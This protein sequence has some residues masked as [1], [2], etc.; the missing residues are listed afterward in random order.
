MNDKELKVKRILFD[1]KRYIQFKF[2]K[3]GLRAMKNNDLYTVENIAI[4]N[5]KDKNSEKI[6]KLVHNEM[7][8]RRLNHLKIGHVDIKEVKNERNKTKRSS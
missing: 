7:D 1:S 5:L 2:I 6:L 3:L 4:D 8:K